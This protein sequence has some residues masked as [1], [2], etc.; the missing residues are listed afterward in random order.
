MAIRSA[1]R[2]LFLLAFYNQYLIE[3]TA[4]QMLKKYERSFNYLQK[5]TDGLVVCITWIFCYT[6]RF[7]FFEGEQGLEWVFS[8]WGVLL[9]VL[10]IYFFSKE[11]LYKSQRYPSRFR[12][13][14]AV[15]QAN[16][17]A[18]IALVMVI[19]FFG[20]GRI[21]RLALL[22]YFAISPFALTTARLLIRN[23]LRHI[24]KQGR[25]LRHLVLIGSGKQLEQYIENI[26]KFKD[27][28]LIV[29][30]RLTLP[31]NNSF[32]KEF[33]LKIE[34]MQ[35]DAIVIGLAADE[36][37][38]FDS[39]LNEIYNTV[40]PIQI[41]PN[42]EEAILG[43]Q[44]DEFNGQI[45][46]HMNQPKFSSIEIFF[47]RFIDLLISTIG[48]VI[49]LPLMIL[50]SL[51]IKLT[52]PGPI[53]YGQER[54]GIDGQKFTMWKFRTM[55]VASAEEDKN[56]WGSKNNPRKTIFGNLLRKS[57]IDELP[58]L[59]N[60]LKGEMSVVG[61][62]PER[63]YFVEQFKKVVPAYMLR[64]KMKAGITGWA[65]I[66]GWRGDTSLDKRIE[67]DLYYIKNWS[68]WLDVKIIFFT[69]WKGF[70]NKNAY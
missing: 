20:D 30:E 52:S 37:K 4:T 23:Y 67:C 64:H 42:I 31:E 17:K 6:F 1:K 21:S 53:F 60:V 36:S 57:S 16:I 33:V 2:L 18:Q 14:L 9:A 29:K 44:I 66:N 10:T 55:K 13:I 40:I 7:R 69:F 50:I 25:N 47:K 63:P 43:Q 19:Y 8:K 58:Q 5:I 46:I 61:P 68:L 24:R 62:R 26:K 27:A 12:E 54:I 32:F 11:G 59:W 15:I 34:K 28:G 49:I 48:L 56:T 35:P 39:L 22:Y 51:I 38:Y 65:Q 70:F 3:I 45:V 41:L